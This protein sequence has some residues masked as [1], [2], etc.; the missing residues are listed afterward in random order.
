MAKRITALL[1][2]LTLV[3]A[4]A[5]CKKSDKEDETTAPET[6]I[7]TDEN[8]ETQIVE[9]EDETEAEEVTNAEGEVVTEEAT[10]AEAATKADGKPA[11]SNP[12]KPDAN[13][14]AANKIPSTPAEVVAAFNNAANAVKADKPGYKKTEHNIIDDIKTGTKLDSMIPGIVKAFPTEG[15]S[16]NVAKGA[17]HNDFPVAGGKTALTVGMV[18]SA[19]AKAAGNGSYTIAIYMKDEKLASLPTNPAATNHGKAFNVLSKAVVDEQ[20]A[21]IPLVSIS[22]FQPTYSG[23]Y[24]KATINADGKMVKAEYLFYTK[25]ILAVKAIGLKLD[26]Y[27]PFGVQQNY[28]INY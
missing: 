1:L 25:A 15:P 19:T 8:G 22:K 16:A 27:V 5:A 9:V 7:V 2:A 28:T 6:E 17:S 26:V 14:P 13:K 3:F 12:A 10:E 23:S 21:S 4:F 11:A 24:V 20:V 18:K